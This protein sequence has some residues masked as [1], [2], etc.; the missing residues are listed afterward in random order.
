MIDLHCHIL[1]GL[2]DGAVDEVA[3]LEMLQVAVDEGITVI[4][5]TPHHR[6]GQF[7]NECEVILASV[8][9]LNVLAKKNNLNIK[10]VPGMEIRL[11]GEIEEDHQNQKIMPLGG[12]T[13]YI[14]V[15]FSNRHI[16]HFTERLFANLQG[17]G[18]HPIIVHPERNSELQSN[19]NKLIQMI[20]KGALVQVTASSLTGHFGRDAQKFAYQLM[21]ADAVHL[22]ASDAHNVTSRGFHMKTAFD[23]INKKY[24]SN[25]VYELQ[26][27]AE[28]IL[29]NKLVYPPQPSPIKR[30]KILGIF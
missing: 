18:L 1:P 14:L 29:K 28:N 26:T 19:P 15:E 7:M 30:K 24:G 13:R 27:N 8:E 16:P 23:V 11:S 21:D 6:N 22:I 4:A 2:D 3:S 17:L 10:I 20:E 12:D 25:Y 9:R 5:G